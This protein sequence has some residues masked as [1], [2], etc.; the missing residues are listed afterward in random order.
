VNTTTAIAESSWTGPGN[1]ILVR[2]CEHYGGIDAWNALR[3]I[4]LI[5][6]RLSGLLPWVKGVGK[7]FPLPSAFEISPHLGLTRFVGYPDVEHAGVF[8]NGAVRIER[9]A[10]G[11]VLTK[12]ENHRDSFVGVAGARRWR[13]LDA[14][15]FFGY[16][17]AHYH[18]LPFTLSQGRLIGVRT[19]GRGGSKSDV[20]DVELP[21]ELHTHCRRQRFYF[22]RQGLLVRHDYNADIV[23]F[24]ARGAHYWNQQTRFNGF[25]ISLDRLVFA[26]AASIALPVITALHA[27]FVDAEVVFEREP[28]R[29]CREQPRPR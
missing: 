7:T 1:D 21:A 16:A 28:E 18:S 3:K 14:L 11:S 10:D 17:L 8:E 4:T 27:T 13:P 29:S 9:V 15:Y 2:A 5:P 20:L 26:R 24:W 12:S 23:G 25:P 19:S 22:D 6:G